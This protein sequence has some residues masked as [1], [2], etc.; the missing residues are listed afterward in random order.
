MQR[1]AFA[2]PAPDAVAGADGVA[3]SL[4]P[5]GGSPTGLPTGPILFKGAIIGR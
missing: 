3:I 4:E 5:V 2:I 1:A